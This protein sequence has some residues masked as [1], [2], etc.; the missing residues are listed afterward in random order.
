VR[1]RDDGGSEAGD[2]GPGQ[3]DCAGVVSHS[4]RKRRAEPAAWPWWSATIG[5]TTS[6]EPSQAR[7]SAG[8]H[9]WTR[10]SPSPGPW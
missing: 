10:R 8:V 4:G 9:P 1:R 2:V 6:D 5:R 7:P 3:R